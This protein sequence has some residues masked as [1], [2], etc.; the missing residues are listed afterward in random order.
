MPGTS[1][2]VIAGLLVSIAAAP[3]HADGVAEAARDI[4]KQV[5]FD[6]T[7]YAP[8]AIH[9]TAERLDWKSSRVFFQHGYLERNP[10][11]TISGHPDDIPLS[12]ED[13]KTVIVGNA[14]MD[15]SSSLINNTAVRVVERILIAKHPDRQKLIRVLGWIERIS[16]AVSLATVQS[17]RHFRQWREND[18][19]AIELGYK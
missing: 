18:R 3:V 11:F 8:A 7:T 13:G 5:V 6:P 14:L 9:Y 19:L 17:S 1:H 10:Q 15:L 2:L 12:Y 4:F 16:Y